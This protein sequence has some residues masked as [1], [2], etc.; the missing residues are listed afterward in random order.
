MVESDIGAAFVNGSY[1]VYNMEQ[2]NTT[3]LASRMRYLQITVM[4]S[5]YICVFHFSIL[6]FL[7]E[8]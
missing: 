1:C 3:L 7:K 2:N 4:K 8:F 6:S 5:G